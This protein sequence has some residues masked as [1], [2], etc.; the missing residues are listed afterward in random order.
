M[1]ATIQAIT[2]LIREY[3]AAMSNAVAAEPHTAT[4]DYWITRGAKLHMQIIQVFQAYN[5]VADAARDVVYPTQETN[6]LGLLRYAVARLDQVD[7]V[8]QEPKL[9]QHESAPQN[10]ELDD[11][12]PVD[13]DMI[14]VALEEELR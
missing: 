1:T 2:E 4:E 9:P 3:A 13:T 12:Q 6:P 5:L 10:Y 11:T 7:C 14:C 8:V